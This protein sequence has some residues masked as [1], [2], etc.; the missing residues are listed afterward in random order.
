MSHLLRQRGLCLH[1]F[2]IF[3]VPF[4]RFCALFTG[5]GSPPLL[6]SPQ[7]ASY[8]NA[9]GGEGT[10]PPPQKNPLICPKSLEKKRKIGYTN[11]RSFLY[12]K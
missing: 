3:R 5:E 2:Y 1:F 4:R 12:I 7:Q 11:K 9:G 6:V 8:H 10:A